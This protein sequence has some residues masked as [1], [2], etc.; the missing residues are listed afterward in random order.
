MPDLYY[1]D[2]PAHL[3][4][5]VCGCDSRSDGFT[6]GHIPF[7]WYVHAACGKPAPLN[8]INAELIQEC[9]FCET[10]YWIKKH[11]D[12]MGLCSSCE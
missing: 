4:D 1:G 9:E 11:P 3:R 10:E 8:A 7:P 2:V 5:K 12:R 6:A